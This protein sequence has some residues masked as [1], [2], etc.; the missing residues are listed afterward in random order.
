[1]PESASQQEVALDYCSIRRKNETE[2]QTVLVLKDRAS[3]ALR[4]WQLQHKGVQNEEPAE[5]AAEGIRNLGYQGRVWIKVDNEPALLALRDEV[6]RKV[7]GACPIE[8]PAHE[9]QSN[10]SIE[11]GVKFLG[12]HQRGT[13]ISP[14]CYMAP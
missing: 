14:M 13:N 10:G 11:N 4:S 9:S 6:M 5:I 12:D 7:P 3:R 2:A 8:A 1:M